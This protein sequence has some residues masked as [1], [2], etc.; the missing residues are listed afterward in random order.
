MMNFLYRFGVSI[1]F[2]SD[3]CGERISRVRQG[4]NTTSLLGFGDFVF[5][6]FYW[7]CMVAR[8]PICFLIFD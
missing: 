2:G 7:P 6:I 3:Y 5:L 4:W 8:I 1:L